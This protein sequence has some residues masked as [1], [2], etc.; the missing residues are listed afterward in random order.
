MDRALEHPEDDR[1]D[2]AERNQRQQRCESRGV[3]HRNAS[4]P[5]LPLRL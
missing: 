2:E 5:I 3:I 1:G 4:F